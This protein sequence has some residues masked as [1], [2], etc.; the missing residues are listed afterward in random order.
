MAVQQ[1]TTERQIAAAQKWATREQVEEA[2]AEWEDAVIMCRAS[3]HS[4]QPSTVTH[5]RHGYTITQACLRPGRIRCG[6]TRTRNMTERGYYTKWK[7]YYPPGYLLVGMGRIDGEGR[8]ALA[9]AS[10][11]HLS[12]VE[13]EDE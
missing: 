8:A 5:D 1:R 13:V 7:P 4:W 9:L 11:R 12:V 6:C 10:I 2:A 3:G